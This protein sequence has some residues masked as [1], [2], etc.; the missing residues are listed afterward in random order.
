MSLNSDTNCDLDPIPTSLLKQCS[1]FLLPIITNIINLSLFAGIFP[2]L[3]SVSFVV[4]IVMFKY[5]V[6]SFRTTVSMQCVTING[7]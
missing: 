6:D 4:V 1:H 7:P 3:S 5:V 2:P